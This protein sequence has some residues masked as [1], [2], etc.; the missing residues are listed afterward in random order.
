VP[1]QTVNLV[2][3]QIT[4]IYVDYLTKHPFTALLHLLELRYPHFPILI[5]I[6]NVINCLWFQFAPLYRPLQSL[7]HELAVDGGQF[8][9]QFLVGDLPTVVFVCSFKQ[10]FR[11]AIIKDAA[12]AF[13]EF[14]ERNALGAVFVKELEEVHDGKLVLLEVLLDFALYLNQAWVLLHVLRDIK[15][16]FRSNCI[17]EYMEKEFPS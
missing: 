7:N 6:V 15:D 1:E 9:D 3:W 2:P 4:R 10:N 5:R 14:S 17:C 11:L 8:I 16:W 12:H 13:F